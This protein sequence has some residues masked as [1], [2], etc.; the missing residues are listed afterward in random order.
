MGIFDLFKKKEEDAPQSTRQ[1]VNISINLNKVNLVKEREAKV[2][3]NLEKKSKTPITANVAFVLDVSDSMSGMFSSGKVQDLVERIYP[4]AVNMDANAELD[5]W[6]FSN[7]QTQTNPINFNNFD[8]YVK[9]EITDSNKYRDVLWNGTSY[10]P[11]ME[12]VKK[13]YKNS[14]LPCY[15]IFITDGDNSDKTQA[16]NIVK[17]TSKLPIFWQFVGI[18]YDSFDF[19]KRLDDMQGRYVDNANFIQMNDIGSLS[20]DELY[21]ELLNEFPDWLNKVRQLGMIG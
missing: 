11:V 21:K 14:K 19:L 8:G 16:E 17:D 9:K 18:G 3:I 20:D 4:M 2:K 5:C 10:A 15:V 12:S 6:I 7:G 1:E 13:Y